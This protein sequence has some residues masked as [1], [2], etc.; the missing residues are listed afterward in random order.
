MFFGE[1][2]HQGMVFK[3]SYLQ[4]VPACQK[5]KRIDFEPKRLASYCSENSS[6]NSQILCE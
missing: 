1:S 3:T 5:S 2:I 6:A 4:F